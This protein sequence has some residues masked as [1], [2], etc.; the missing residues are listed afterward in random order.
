MIISKKQSGF[1]IVELLIVVV[2]IG[3]L[4]AIVIVAYNGIQDSARATAKIS[5]IKTMQKAIELYYAKNGT[6]PNTGGGWLYQRSAGNNFIPGVVPEF[7]SKLPE[8][9]DGPTGSNTNNTYIYRSDTAGTWYEL[10]RLYQ[11]S[12]PA[13]EY[14]NIPES[15]H[16]PNPSYTDRWGVWSN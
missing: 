11:P 9:T 10:K 1:T 5:D 16:D 15:M 12:I 3:I 7:M 14:S 4:A 2:V 8:I 13:G 6:Y